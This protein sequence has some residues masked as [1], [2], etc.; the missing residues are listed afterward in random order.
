MKLYKTYSD[1]S[2]H[3]YLIP[4]DEFDKFLE[5][6]EDL[7]N[8]VYSSSDYETDEEEEYH[9]NAVDLRDGHFNKYERLEGEEHYIILESDLGENI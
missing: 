1:D 2:G 7:E 6:L 4:K 9:W 5:E 3:T 8:A